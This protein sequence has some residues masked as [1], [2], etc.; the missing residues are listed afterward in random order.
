MEKREQDILK[1][2]ESKTNE[3]KVPERLEPLQ[4]EKML[5]EKGDRKK[6]TRTKIYRFATLAAACALLAAGIGVYQTADTWGGTKSDS[7]KEPAESSSEESA[8][9]EEGNAQEPQGHIVC[10]GPN[11]V[12]QGKGEEKQGHGTQHETNNGDGHG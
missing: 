4:I 6:K 10:D 7:T 2:I 8:I 1:K 3:V 12:G 5:E 11:P 9:V